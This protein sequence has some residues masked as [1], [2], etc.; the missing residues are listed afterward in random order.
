M[1]FPYSNFAIKDGTMNLS[2]ENIGG[3]GQIMDDKRTA[4]M[5]DDMQCYER[6]LIL[7]NVLAYHGDI[8]MC[9]VGSSA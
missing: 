6:R 1:T 3:I 5:N 4:W 7:M 8:F 2:C 9:S